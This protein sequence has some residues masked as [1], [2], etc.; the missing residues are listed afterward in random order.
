MVLDGGPPEI[1]DF[2]YINLYAV[3]F[4]SLHSHHVFTTWI[5]YFETLLSKFYDITF[6]KI[7]AMAIKA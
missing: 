3:A 1:F 6:I 5:E 7:M 2:K 4:L